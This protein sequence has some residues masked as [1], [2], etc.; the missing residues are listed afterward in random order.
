[1]EGSAQPEPIYAPARYAPHMSN[2]APE[3]LTE[4]AAGI[5]TVASLMGHPTRAAMLAALV[6]GASLPAGQLAQLAYVTPSTASE[7]LARLVEGGLLT[8]VSSGRHRYY[9]LR[10]ASVAQALEAVSAVGAPPAVRRGTSGPSPEMR[11]ARS[12]YDHLAGTLGVG[13]TD[14]M[15][16][17][18]TLI[19]GD[20]TFELTPPGAARLAALGVDV[21]QAQS[22]K[23]RFSPTCL[24]WTERRLHLAGALGA[25]ILQRF[26]D[27]RWVAR[28]AEGRSLR[29]T[30]A[31]QRLLQREF[32]LDLPTMP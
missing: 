2:T 30:V 1:M 12:C 13:L 28:R 25:A 27:S 23:R 4:E 17:Q 21:A 7:H 10:D 9:R 29:I 22:R 6:G 20:R 3:V 24:D 26:V 15:L 18:G 8:V 31:G 19:P 32:D 5:S 11:L 16:R 14:A